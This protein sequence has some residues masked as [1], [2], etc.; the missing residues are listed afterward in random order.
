MVGSQAKKDLSER[1]I[2]TKYITPALARAGWDIHGQIL[3]NYNVTDGEVV[4]RGRASK[5]KTAQ[6]ADYVLWHKPGIPLAIV[7]AKDNKHTVAAG[8][9]QAL[10][11]AAMIDAPFAFSS[12]GDG[13]LLHDRTGAANPIETSLGL[14]DFPSPDDLWR[15][16]RAAK[17]LPPDVEPAVTQDYHFAAGAHTPRYYQVTAINRVVEAVARG[18]KRLLLVMATGTGKTYTAFQFIWRLWK[19]KVKR[20]ILFLADRNALLDQTKTGDFKPFGAAM[21]QITNRKVDTAFEIYLALY[22]AISQND[23]DKD[24]FRQFSPTFFDLIVVDECHRGSAADNSAWRE[25]LDYFSAATQIGLTATPKETADVSTT[26]Y[27]GEA[28]YTYSLKQGIEDGFLAP[29]KVVRVDLDKDLAG[30]R[31]EKGKVDKSGLPIEDKVYGQR[32]FDRS[33]VLTKRTELVAKKLTRYLCETN[34]WDK[35]IVFCEDIDHADRMRTALQNDNADLCAQDSRYVMKITG[36][37]VDGKRELWSFCH[38][39]E[40]YPTLVTTSKLLTTGIDAKTCKVIVLDQNIQSMTEFKQIIGRGT[41]LLEEHGKMFFTILDF[42]RA[43]ELFADPAFDGDAVQIHFPQG[44]GPIAPPDDGDGDDDSEGSGEIH[45]FDT[46]D[47]MPGHEGASPGNDGPGTIEFNTDRGGKR[48]KYVVDDVTVSIIGERVQ[49]YG[50]D[51]KLVVESLRDYCKN[52]L[53]ERFP[54]AASFDAAWAAAPRKQDLVEELSQRGVFF[55]E[56]GKEVGP[57]L[58][59]YDLVRHVA[60][61]L[62]A[63][64]RKERAEAVRA[65][66]PFA[67]RPEPQRA[68]LS[69]LLDKAESGVDD[70]ENIGLLKVPP[71]PALGTTVELISRFGSKEGYLAAVRELQAALQAA[72]PDG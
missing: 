28:I 5:R 2:C 14:D 55:T 72:F 22:Q 48:I 58:S 25:V 45:L 11:Y 44:D 21:T 54:T 26:S 65:T 32:D 43:T 9:Q 31:P 33:L 67:S 60:Y 30:W 16:S 10:R 3:E 52:L 12:N 50:P 68:V 47:D 63:R 40:R 71:L 64:T 19:A 1:D 24:V 15:R 62:R 13:F 53:R 41:R 27:F 69:A 17:N 23:P 39:E 59:P 18:D 66:P 29:Y 56:L 49:H 36:D 51:G 57:D 35:T 7:E 38:P 70:L 6:F 8:I 34:R 61:D 20:R 4:V 37:D 46:P 42:R